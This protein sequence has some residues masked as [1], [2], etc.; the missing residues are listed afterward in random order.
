MLHKD[1]TSGE[2]FCSLADTG[3]DMFA[4]TGSSLQIKMYKDIPKYSVETGPI[5]SNNI[6][7][8]EP[9]VIHRTDVTDP[10]VDPDSTV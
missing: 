10:H 8:S 6:S 1:S 2:F 3:K 7:G 4:Q 9:D 5:R